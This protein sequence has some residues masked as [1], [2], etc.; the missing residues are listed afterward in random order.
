MPVVVGID[1]DGDGTGFE[2]LPGARYNGFNRGLGKADL[3]R[4]VGEFNQKYAGTRT[5][6]NQLVSALRLPS[7]YEFGDVFTS[8]DIRLGRAFQV[9]ERLKIN[10]YGEIFNMFNVAN[11]AGFSFALDQPTAFGQPTLRSNQ[12]FGSGAPRVFQLGARVSF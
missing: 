4:L 3:E 11:L 2:P 10:V 8:Q 6:R 7:S 12:I 5:P 1:L 9:K